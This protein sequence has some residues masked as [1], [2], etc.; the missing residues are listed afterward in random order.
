VSIACQEARGVFYH[1]VKGPVQHRSCLTSP[2]AH[3]LG[4]LDAVPYSRSILHQTAPNPTARDTRLAEE[5]AAFR[6]LHAGRLYGFALVLELGDAARAAVLAS[7]A[8]DAGSRRLGELRHPE[9]AAA[10]L[11]ERVFAAHRSDRRASATAAARRAEELEAL[12]VGERARVALAALTP[13]ERAALVADQ[14]ERLAP[15]DTATIVRLRGRRLNR[16]LTRARLRYA[17]AFAA[18]PAAATG[19]GDGPLARRVRALAARALP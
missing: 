2:A 5:R 12:G 19:V 4:T 13:R 14:V 11:R 1:A 6:E 8:I 15:P 7:D 17:A 3:P 16:L 18:A 10:W 9:R